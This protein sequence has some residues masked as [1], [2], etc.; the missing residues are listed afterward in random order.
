MKRVNTIN[1]C[2]PVQT[3]RAMAKQIALLDSGAT[4]NFISYSTWKQLGIRK[5][6]LEEPI[7]VHNINRTEKKGARSDTTVGFKYS[8]MANIEFKSSS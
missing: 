4:E 8:I 7:T 5:Q 2:V 1:L 6:E 3:A